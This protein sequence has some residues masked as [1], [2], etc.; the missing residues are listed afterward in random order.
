MKFQQL[1]IGDRFEYEGSV[2]VKVGPLVA[3]EEASGR[4]QL[5]PRYAALRPVSASGGPVAQPAAP[6]GEA[7]LE[8]FHA[9]CVQLI[10]GLGLPCERAEQAKRELAQA[11]E[12]GLARLRNGGGAA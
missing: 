6:P 12:A 1:K 3:R 2:H 9:R 8:A 7:A 10:D 4:Q 11:R 5:I